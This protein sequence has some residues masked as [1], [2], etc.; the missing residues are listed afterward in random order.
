M[1]YVICWPPLVADSVTSP[2]GVD[3]DNVCADTQPSQDA[4]A[5]ASTAFM[6]LLRHRQPS[7]FWSLLLHFASCHLP[8]NVLLNKELVIVRRGG[9]GGA[10]GS[11]G[12]GGVLL[13][14]CVGAWDYH[15][16]MHGVK[17]GKAPDHS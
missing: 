17:D 14:G 9:G 2:M 11:A 15:A 1:I 4:G 12:G 3:G 6:H 7:I 8:L 13:G 5:H 10:G 16:C